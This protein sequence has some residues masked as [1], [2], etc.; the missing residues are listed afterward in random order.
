MNRTLESNS[1]LFRYLFAIKILH[2]HMLFTV[3]FDK[4]NKSLERAKSKPHGKFWYWFLKLNNFTM[5]HAEVVLL[6]VNN[7]ERFYLRV[8]KFL[9][10]W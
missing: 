3:C 10:I 5:K 8:I 9:F 2:N 6:P 1:Y 4:R 7:S